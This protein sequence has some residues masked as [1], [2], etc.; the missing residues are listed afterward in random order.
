MQIG[1][2]YYRCREAAERDAAMRTTSDDVRA[3]RIGIAER[4]ARLAA[5]AEMSGT[6]EL[7]HPLAV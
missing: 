1:I 5:Q 7:D 6:R 4:Y 2:D 3:I